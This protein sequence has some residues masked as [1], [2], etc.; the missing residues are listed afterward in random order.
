MKLRR[1]SRNKPAGKALALS[2]PA[3]IP[4][5]RAKKIA[6]GANSSNLRAIL[7]QRPQ[8]NPRDH[9]DQDFGAPS[10]DY[11][12]V[13]SCDEKVARIVQDKKRPQDESVHKLAHQFHQ[14]ATAVG[15]LQLR[16]TSVTN[17]C[18][19]ERIQEELNSAELKSSA[20]Q[21]DLAFARVLTGGSLSEEQNLQFV[22]KWHR[23]DTQDVADITFLPER[24]KTRTDR[25]AQ[26]RLELQYVN[27][28]IGKMLF[29][30]RDNSLGWPEKKRKP[31]PSS[32]VDSDDSFA[33]VALLW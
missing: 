20:S 6:K 29:Q 27:K 5:K 7:P 25:N 26:H 19:L 21:G 22:A 8:F 28:R 16:D 4:N 1:S 9:K 18:L 13:R 32:S 10:V 23:I 17:A 15:T 11:E 14:F 12:A 33:N 24:T 2:S 30:E 31:L 3:K